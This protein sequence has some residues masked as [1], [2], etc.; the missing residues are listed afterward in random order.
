M[1]VDDED[2]WMT[3]KAIAELFERDRSVIIK[4]LGNIYNDEE[5]DKQSTCAKF[6]HVQTEGNR[7]V[8]RLLEFYA[9]RASN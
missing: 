8:T 4:H 9:L 6:A 3:Q 1:R 5:L 2:F 7:K